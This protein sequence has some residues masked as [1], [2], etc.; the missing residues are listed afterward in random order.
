MHRM[1][2][3]NLRILRISTLLVWD[4]SDE[5]KWGG[6]IVSLY[7]IMFSQDAIFSLYLS[8]DMDFLHSFIRKLL[9]LPHILVAR[10]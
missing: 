4:I 2:V 1:G 9:Y 5:L 7:E 8:I 10:R 6:H 3:F